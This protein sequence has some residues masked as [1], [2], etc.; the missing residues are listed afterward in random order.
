MKRPYIAYPESG[1]L[2]PE[3]TANI[4]SQNKIINLNINENEKNN[5]SDEINSERE[6]PLKVSQLNT[7]KGNYII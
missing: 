7:E 5:K 2:Y 6:I 4:S 3:T 1:H